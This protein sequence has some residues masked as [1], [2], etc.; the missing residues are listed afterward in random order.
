MKVLVLG[1]CGM[2]G[3]TTASDLIKWPE[4]SRLTLA[5][6]K[7]DMTGINNILRSSPKVQTHEIDITDYESL[8]KLAKENDIVVNCCGPFYKFGIIPM[9]ATID[10]GRNYVDICDDADVIQEAF[11][12][13]EMAQNAGVSVCIGCGNSPGFSNAVIKSTADKLDEV[14]EIEILVAIGLGGGFGPGVLYHIF[15]CLHDCNLQ[16]IDGKLQTPGDWGKQEIQFSETFGKH[17]VYY[18]GHPEPVTMPRYIKGVKKIVFKLGNLPSWINEWLLKCIQLGLASPQPI[19]LGDTPVVPRD[20]MISELSGSSHLGTEK[21][22]Y[23]NA[24]RYFIVKGKEAGKEVTYTWHMMGLPKGMTGI[25]CSFL[26]RMVLGGEVNIKGVLSP[27]AF[28]DTRKLLAF[29]EERGMRLRLTKTIS[30]E[31]PYIHEMS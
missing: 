10:A 27:E 14:D 21:E 1:G 12:L 11:T 9:K 17:A 16:Y 6:R 19:I 28:V 20:F 18:F 7:I 29:W 30:G 22:L 8:V 24:E 25:N 13:D 5:D 26:S 23:T 2:S 15:H 4:V 3:S 31:F